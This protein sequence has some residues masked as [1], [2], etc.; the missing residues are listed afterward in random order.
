MTSTVS[1]E[2]QKPK[3]EKT[4]VI[5]KKRRQ[6]LLIRNAN[7][8]QHVSPKLVKKLWLIAAIIEVKVKMIEAKT[9]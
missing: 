3:V 2:I 9:V 8:E 6:K 1:K 5:N 7:C 4:R